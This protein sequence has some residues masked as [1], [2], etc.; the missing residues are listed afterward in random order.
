VGVGDHGGGVNLVGGCLGWSIHGE[1]AG[2][3]GGEIADEVA[4]RNRSREGV[5]RV[6]N[7]AVNLASQPN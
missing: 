7:G 5:R 4:G 3:R 2:A 1:V 6:C